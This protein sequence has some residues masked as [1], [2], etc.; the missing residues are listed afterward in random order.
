MQLSLNSALN[1]AD[2][3]D[4]YARDKFVQIPN[5]LPD[6]LANEIHQMLKDSIQWRLVFPDE[7]GQVVQVTREIA[8]EKGMP[9]VQEHIQAVHERAQQNIG[10]LYNSYPM[11][12]AVFE[13]ADPGHPIHELTNFLNSREFLDF[14]ATVIGH[15]AITK[16]DAQA[17]FYAQGH[18]LTRHIDD[19]E[20][21]ERRAAYTLGFSQNWQPDW[22]G[23]LMFLDKDLDISKAF[24]PRFNV[25]TLF[26][27][28]Q[29]HSV[30]PVSHF[31]GGPRLSITGWLRDDAI[32]A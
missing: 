27:G 1:A 24:I 32:P 12:Q 28:L 26:D 30:S 13:N 6:V 15:D 23:L 3:R 22:G 14:G 19:G 4:Q 31:A 25:L 17:T 20:K 21:K 5:F 18:F 2:Y 9:W 29:V 7:T 8:Q 16:A 10:F 11:I